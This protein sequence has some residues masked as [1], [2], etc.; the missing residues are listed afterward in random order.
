MMPLRWRRSTS[1]QRTTIVVDD[2]SLAETVLGP[3]LGALVGTMK[4]G[5]EVH[6]RKKIE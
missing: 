6:D 4:I 5:V 3:E 2:V 1:F